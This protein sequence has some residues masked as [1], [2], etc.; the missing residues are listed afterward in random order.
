MTT[1]VKTCFKCDVEKPLSEF[2]KHSRMADGHLNKCKAC[3]KHDQ[4]QHR[5]DPRFREKVLEYDRKRGSRQGTS[6][7]HEYRRREPEKVKAHNAVSNAIRD[8]KLVRPEN[9]SHCHKVC[10]PH[11]HHPDYSKPLDVVWLCAE[12]HTALHALLET[13]ERESTQRTKAMRSV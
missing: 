7:L 3:T 10:K 9:C 12:C 2:Y 13:V 8:G 11:G 5:R 4:H 6:Y 1:S